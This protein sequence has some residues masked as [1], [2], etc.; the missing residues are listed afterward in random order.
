[1]LGAIGVGEDRE[2]GRLR[3]VRRPHL[4]PRRPRQSE[5]PGSWPLTSA[6]SAT[7][8]TN[9]AAAGAVAGQLTRMQRLNQFPSVTETGVEDLRVAEPSHAQRRMWASSTGLVII[10][11]CPESMLINSTRRALE[12]S[13]IFPASTQPR[14]SAG[15]NSG[16]T[17]TAGTS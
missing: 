7:A 1:M 14:T 9:H 13:G 17:T 10:G 2:R 16:Q 4:R 3:A 15:V 6:T 5:P 8:A 11:Q 12:S